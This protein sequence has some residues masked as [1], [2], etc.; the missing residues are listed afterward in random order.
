[1]RESGM[2]LDGKLAWF[3]LLLAG[4]GCSGASVILKTPIANECAATGLKGCPEIADG[5]L[6]YVEGD[7]AQALRSLAAGAAQN[8]PVEV[9]RFA[10][11]VAALEAVP[12]AAPYA[13]TLQE[14][15]QVLLANA[16]T[17]QEPNSVVPAGSIP[18]SNGEGQVHQ[19]PGTHVLTADTDPSRSRSGVAEP[20]AGN[21]EPGWC[22]QIIGEVSTCS[23][24]HRGPLFVTDVASLGP[25]CAGQFVAVLGKSGRPKYL[26]SGPFDMHGAR[27][28]LAPDDTLV[29]G[30][31]EQRTASGITPP[32]VSASDEAAVVLEETD[33]RFQCRLLWSGFQPYENHLATPNSSVQRV[34][35]R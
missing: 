2:G 10:D 13:A 25:A 9:R 24:L 16:G 20:Y 21:R 12:G 27:L 26:L 33:P 32:A 19:A 30:Q 23:V 15:V 7:K 4:V 5:M 14:A 28:L 35:A 22:R 18:P 29:A 1:M 17:A 8:S 34:Q 11:A 6:L 3:A 31:V